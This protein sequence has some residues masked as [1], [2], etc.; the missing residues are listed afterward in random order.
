MPS[1]WVTAV[2]KLP[3]VRPLGQLLDEGHVGLVDGDDE[4]GLLIR[5]QV[6]DD[7]DGAHVGGAQLAH[8]EGG[9]GRLGDEV[10]LLGLSINITQKNIVRDDIFHKGGLVVLLLIVGLGPVEGHHRHG[11]QGAGHL[12]LPLHKGGIVELS[13]PA[14]QGLEGLSLKMGGGVV[15]GIDGGHRAGPMLA[16]AGQF[17]ARHH[18]PVCIDHT[19]SAVDAVFH[20]EYHSLKHPAGHMDPSQVKLLKQLLTL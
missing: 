7:V 4:V 1:S 18:D 10:Q 8:Q 20:L 17:T 6:L 15:R 14:R 2:A 19:H 12:V 13:P 11:A 16:N 5:E 9:P 3:G